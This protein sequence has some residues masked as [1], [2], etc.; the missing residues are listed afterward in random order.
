MFSPSVH[1]D[2]TWQAVKDYQENI[3]KVTE[4]QKEQLQFDHYNPRDLQ[5]T[6]DTHHKVM[7]HMKT[8]SKSIICYINNY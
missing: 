4:T 1:V 2:L 8:S 3:M 6:T 7:L 5:S